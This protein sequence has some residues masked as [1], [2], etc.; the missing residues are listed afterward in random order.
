M[1]FTLSTLGARPALLHP[2]QLR[3]GVIDGLSDLGLLETL[4][5][6]MQ[7]SGELEDPWREP[8]VNSALDAM[9][10][11]VAA[12]ELCGWTGPPEDPGRR[13]ATGADADALKRLLGRPH[14][15]TGGRDMRRLT[16]RN[17]ALDGECWYVKRDAGNRPVTEVR[18]RPFSMTVHA[19][20]DVEPDLNGRRL[21][22]WKVCGERVPREALIQFKVPDR[23]N[24]IRGLNRAELLQQTASIAWRARTYL[25]AFFRNGA[26]T[27]GFFST[28]YEMAPAQ[29][30][31][32][33]ELFYEEHGGAD[34]FNKV[35]VLPNGMKFQNP[36]Q[37]HAHMEL[38]KILE[39][40]RDELLMMLR[41][42]KEVLGL[43]DTATYSN[44][45]TA[46]SGFWFE[47]LFP[48]MREIEEGLND[49]VY[50]LSLAFGGV[51]VGFDMKH[52]EDVLKRWGEK[53][54]Q[55]GKAVT[56]GI[57]RNDAVRMLE[58]P[59]APVPGG[60]VA[61]VQ[62]ALVP[63]DMAGVLAAPSTPS[64]PRALS[65]D[66]VD[67]IATRVARC[68]RREGSNPPPAPATPRG[69]VR[70]R[71]ALRHQVLALRDT[72]ERQM[73]REIRAVFAALRVAQLEVLDVFGTDDGR[74]AADVRTLSP[75][76]VDAHLADT[77]RLKEELVAR[78][79]PLYD[80]ALAAA[81]DQVAD[82]LGRELLIFNAQH[83]RALALIQTKQVQ[84]TGILDTVRDR[85]RETLLEGAEA[86]ELPRALKD[87]VRD[88]MNVANKRAMDIA[89]QEAAEVVNGGRY[90]TMRAEGV[91]R[92]V[93][94]DAGDEKVRESH[95]I[96]GEER[97]IGKP[98][99]N[100]LLY[101]NDPAAPASEVV[102][103]RCVALAA[104]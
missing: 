104:D 18:A 31:E 86:N 38:L 36:V 87:R 50:G 39:W 61:L 77:A 73:V 94:S 12:V 10:V 103:C 47:N 1:K 25:D 21:I 75:Q 19:K 6:M 96:D 59:T 63:I 14:A 27:G 85:L 78:M 100:G 76:D 58:I 28:D 70:A 16:V 98:F 56:S 52:V 45:L 32:F 4:K 99:S 66:E 95:R 43:L 2:R 5:D 54:D 26:Q 15:M 51:Y 7:Q 84:V 101:P 3:S 42:P 48:L 13:R 79:T 53:F 29:V 97:E 11:N 64:E 35:G 62:G 49:P 33:L 71:G 91:E 23:W 9:E 90:E 102:R 44:G 68:F 20:R 30:R 74:A 80:A 93:W 72:H 8:T 82:E 88:V 81:A 37:N 65:D 55:L 46:H 83:P 69:G 60:D 89:Q 41:T 57:P 34:R 67:R 22:G 24:T 92:H 17:Q 40:A